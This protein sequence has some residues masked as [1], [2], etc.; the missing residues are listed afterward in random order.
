M[1]KEIGEMNENNVE[2]NIREI[3]QNKII[4][5][6]NYFTLLDNKNVADIIICRNIIIPKIFFIE[7]K[8]YSDKKG[9]IGFGDANGG[10]FQP[11]ILRKRPAYLE[12]NLI[13]VFQKEND[14]KYYV[15]NND[16]C[17][18]Y[19]SGGIIGE[20]GGKQNNFQSKLFENIKPLR[21][22]DFSIWLENWLLK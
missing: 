14:K 2:N 7:V 16:D 19:I 8:H 13:W 10:G 3:I 6:K 12:D 15:L 22:N 11:E 17:I 9:R 18:K 5:S 21:E 20:V 1:K 4:G